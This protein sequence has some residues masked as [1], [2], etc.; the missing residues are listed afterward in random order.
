MRKD[1]VKYREEQIGWMAVH[2]GRLFKAGVADEVVVVP[3]CW[4][5]HWIGGPNGEPVSLKQL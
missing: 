3:H 5:H 2:A 1:Q 4:E